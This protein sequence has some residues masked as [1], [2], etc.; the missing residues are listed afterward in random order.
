MALISSLASAS[1]V[2]TEPMSLVSM[3]LILSLSSVSRSS[4]RR[5]AAMNSGEAAGMVCPEDSLSSRGLTRAF[6]PSM[7]SMHRSPLG[8]AEAVMLCAST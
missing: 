8:V 6:P 2:L 1:R 3:A 4:A 7:R 5:K